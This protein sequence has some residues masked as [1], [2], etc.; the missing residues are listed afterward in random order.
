[1]RIN[2]IDSFKLLFQHMD[3]PPS[4][5]LLSLKHI[6]QIINL[7]KQ[8]LFLLHQLIRILPFRIQFRFEAVDEILPVSLFLS[9]LFF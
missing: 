7:L 6:L 4:T 1:M 2:N 8:F 3:S 5:R 9:E